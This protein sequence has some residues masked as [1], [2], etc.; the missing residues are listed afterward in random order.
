MLL[1]LAQA[2]GRELAALAGCS[3]AATV[4]ARVSLPHHSLLSP[5]IFIPFSLVCLFLTLLLLSVHPFYSSH[6]ATP[7]CPNISFI[8]SSFSFFNTQMQ[9]FC[10]RK[11]TKKKKGKAASIIFSD[12]FSV[13]ACNN[14]LTPFLFC[15]S[16]L[17]QASSVLLLA[18]RLHKDAQCHLPVPAAL[19]S[20][21]VV[22]Q[23]A[24]GL[25]L[26]T[27][28]PQRCCPSLADLENP[29]HL[30]STRNLVLER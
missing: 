6:P 3:S 29:W 21:V 11:A 20:L 12:H 26:G 10:L 24:I 2:G 28:P 4:A 25:Q 19:L 18:H 16:D 17:V 15:C 7:L 30:C 23:V 8:M 9:R 1:Q 13:E 14:Y 22:E 5:P 27:F